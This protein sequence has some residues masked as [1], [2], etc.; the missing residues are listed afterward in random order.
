MELELSIEDLGFATR[1]AARQL[2]RHPHLRRK[3]I[4]VEKKV[5][6]CESLGVIEVVSARRR[7]LLRRLHVRR[8]GFSIWNFGIEG[9]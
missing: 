6:F 3:V 9:F 8:Q 2:L 7:R 1:G 5:C 4:I